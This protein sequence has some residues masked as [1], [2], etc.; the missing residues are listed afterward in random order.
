MRPNTALLL[1]FCL[2]GFGLAAP[3][4]AQQVCLPS[5]RLLTIMP[6]GGQAGTSVEVSITG[7][8]AEDVSALLF[9]TP[10]I[11]A[12]P[13]LGA[14]GK[15]VESKF[16][17]AI[18]A[19]APVGVYDARVLSRLGVSSARAFSV[20]KLPEITRTKPNDSVEK[21]LALSM[22][23]LCNAVM[24]KRA[25]D[26]Y[27]FQAVK[28]KRVAVDCATVGIDSKLTPVLIIG[29]AQGRDLLVN[30]TG[31]VL[32]FTPPA[33]GTFLIK[34]HGLTFQG[35]AESFYRLALQEINGSGPAPH[36]PVT[37]K[38]S[39]MSWPPAGLPATAQTQEVEPNNQ[40]GQAQKITLPCDIAGSFFPAA[41]VDTYEFT[42]K[43]GEVWWVEVASERLGLNTDPFVLVQ[44]VKKTGDK[45][46]LADVAELNDI[47]SPMKISSNGYS[48]DGPVYD[49]GSPDVL[50][51]VDIKEDGLYRLQLRDL[52]GG[53]RNEPGNV[54]RLIVRKAAPDFALAAWAVHMTLRNGDRAALSKPIALRAGAALAF[55]VVVI[56]RDGFDGEIEISM[57]GLPAGMT[58][59]GLTIPA[60][61]AVGHLIINAA[62]NAKPGHSIASLFGRAKINGETV[63]R[64]CRVASVAWPVKDAKGE[65]PA[66]RL[67]ADIPVSVTDSEQAPITI[68]VENKVFEAKVGESL[69]IPLKATWRNDF[70]GTS[71]KL[72]AYGAGFESVKEFDLPIKAATQEAVLDLAALKT[73]PGDYTI[74]FYGI[75]I[76][77]YR[78][79]PEAVKLAQEAQKKAEQEALAVATSS[80]KLI[81]DAAGT[82]PSNPK[83]DTASAAKIAA[84]KQKLAEAAK[85]EATKRMKTVTEAAEPKD[86]V[87]IFVSQ[88]VRISVKAAQVASAA[89]A[90]K[91]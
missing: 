5:P 79:N 7:E 18:A 2:M 48:Y 16:L 36:Q 56:R 23:S 67:M 47:T 70:T 31:G 54:Y 35:G 59:T 66:P 90:E 72:K 80:K 61:K 58:A 22:N 89:T 43:K 77:K 1:V 76:S 33:D 81:T 10:K 3:A 60:G 75:G 15:A 55:E 8:N 74:A 28:G 21:A 40:Q 87:D 12:K 41:D 6:M 91:K 44:Q 49:A 52:F 14:D 71:I 32:D 85:T 84:E 4:F 46:T 51:K 19:D 57:D 42:A 26:F 69:K 83:S 78:Y 88:P 27:S 17:V 38:V 11:T 34:V 29:D 13:V 50:G 86:T 82:T 39:S 30:R 73:P 62:E 20:G 9:S 65:I 53:T 68:A 37:A 64:S 25:V 24:T 45:E 63:T